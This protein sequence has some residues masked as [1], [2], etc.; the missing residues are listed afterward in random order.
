[1]TNFGR[2][3][4]AA[5]ALTILVMTGCG[6]NDSQVNSAY[7]PPPFYNPP[8]N[9][10]PPPVPTYPAYNPEPR[11]ISSPYNPWP[12]PT[13]PAYNPAFNPPPVYIPPPTYV[14]PMRMH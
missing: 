9:Y 13:P 12:V 8:T 1:M 11:Y 7:T 5:A 6:T 2:F 10:N 14:P 3:F 4:A